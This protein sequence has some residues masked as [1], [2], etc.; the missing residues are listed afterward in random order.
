VKRAAVVLLFLAAILRP[1]TAHAGPPPRVAEIVGATSDAYEAALVDGDP[2][3]ATS[4]GLVIVHDGRVAKV[5]TSIDG[6]PGARLR[7]ISVLAD[8]IY[9]GGVDGAAL[10]ARDAHVAKTFPVP[11]VRRVV[12][13]RG[14]R[15]AATFGGGLVRLGDDCKASPVPAIGARESV[16][17]LVAQGDRLYVATAHA[18]VVRLD[19]ALHAERTFRAKNGLTDDVVWGLA[20]AEGKVL[21]ATSRGVS[22]IDGDRAEIVARD[23][24]V[25]DVRAV[26]STPGALYVATFGGGAQRV[27]GARLGRASRTRSVLPTPRGVLVVHDAGVDLVDG[28]GR[29]TALLSGGLPSADLTALAADAGGLWVGTFDRGLVRVTN[30]GVRAAP[31]LDPRVNDVVVH[32]GTTYV[33]TDGGL[34]T[35]DGTRFAPIE[36]LPREHTSAVHVDSRTGDVWVS[37]AHTLARLHAGAWTAWRSEDVPA[38]SQLD[39]VMT[40]D[41]GRVWTGGLHGLVLFDPAR[42]TAEITRASSG[43]L[44]VDWVTALFPWQGNVAV[45]TYNGGLAFLGSAPRLLRES[46]GLPAGWINPRAIKG[47]RGEIWFGALDRGLVYGA[48]GAWGR[49]GLGEHL[50][51]ADVTAILADGDRAAWVATRGGLARVSW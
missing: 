5:L 48:P 2:W 26:A 14:A 24:P 34:Y 20:A 18:G 1:S 7:S 11:R 31:G 42:G 35:G 47:V 28:A 13:F 6:L 22:A 16:T 36:S 43:A 3:I 51:S 12:F 17:D 33:A 10:V 45:G 39:A 30:D 4:G 8:G 50:P 46:D 44:A 38:L 27:H 23:L 32:G 29:S 41:A 37:G 21:A 15:Y 49:L 9:V 25:P 19:G 40:D